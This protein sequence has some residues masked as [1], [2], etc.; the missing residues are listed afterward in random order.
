MDKI[1]KVRKYSTVI[2]DLD[3]TIADLTHRLHFIIRP[4]AGAAFR[5]AREVAR[6]AGWTVGWN[7][8]EKGVDLNIGAVPSPTTTA[9]IG[10][11]FATPR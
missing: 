3:G 11:R 9:S 10:A 8:L 6:A 5:K 7:P 1:I 4:G 2:C